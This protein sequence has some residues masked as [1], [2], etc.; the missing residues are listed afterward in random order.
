MYIT[1][2]PTTKTTKQLPSC[3][4]DPK[5]ESNLPFLGSQT[6][7]TSE[8]FVPVGW[9]PQ[10][11]WSQQPDKRVCSIMRL[12][13]ECYS[14]QAQMCSLSTIITNSQCEPRLDRSPLAFT[15]TDFDST[16]HTAT[17]G[18][19]TVGSNNE[20]NS[21]DRRA[22]YPRVGL[23]LRPKRVVVNRCDVMISLYTYQLSNHL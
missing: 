13:G 23:L 21:G 19:W 14:K 6:I 15:S 8:P 7:H 17:L 22:N 12:I 5:G 4:G 20:Y 9:Q 16:N 1:S 18:R 11:H 2:R 10:F 3:V